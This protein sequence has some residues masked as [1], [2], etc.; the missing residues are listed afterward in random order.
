MKRMLYALTF[1]LLLNI[2]LGFTLFEQ[3]KQN[4]TITDQAFNNFYHHLNATG[5]YLDKYLDEKEP[6]L[7]ARAQN[8]ADAAMIE[9]NIISNHFDKNNSLSTY[10]NDFMGKIMT[11]DANDFNDEQISNYLLDINSL[12]ET[13]L[14]SDKK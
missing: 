5:I 13:I 9:A 6:S 4:A 8:S 3:W 11:I 2:F 14:S 1:S 12:K 10:M 7:L